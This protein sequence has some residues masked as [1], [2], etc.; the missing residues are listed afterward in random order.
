MRTK[1]GGGDGNQ[2]CGQRG[3]SGVNGGPN[4]AAVPVRGPL[5]AF[6]DRSGSGDCRPSQGHQP[7]TF[8]RLIAIGLAPLA[9]PEISNADRLTFHIEASAIFPANVFAPF[10]VSLPMLQCV[11]VEPVAKFPLVAWL[12]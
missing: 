7:L 1:A 9:K 6:P 10:A 4:A 2:N 3:V 5:F 8:I 12:A 11:L